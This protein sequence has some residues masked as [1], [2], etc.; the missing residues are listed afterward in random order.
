MGGGV[1]DG[2]KAVEILPKTEIAP[3]FTY[4]FRQN[5]AAWKAELEKGAMS[6]NGFG[7]INKKDEC[8]TRGWL[9]TYFPLLIDQLKALF[10]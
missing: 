3:L 8:L 2:P 10:L 6:G 4:K 5:P 1:K 9:E 7:V